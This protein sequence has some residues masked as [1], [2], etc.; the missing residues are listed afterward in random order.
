MLRPW[1]NKNPWSPSTPKS[2]QQTPPPKFK[3]CAS[4]SLFAQENY[5]GE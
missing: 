4:C 2:S 5:I 3:H 1:L